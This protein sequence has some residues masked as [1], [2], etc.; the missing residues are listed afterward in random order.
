MYRPLQRKNI[1]VGQYNVEIPTLVAPIE[2]VE[3]ANTPPPIR[4][5]QKD[6]PPTKKSKPKYLPGE[7][8][9]KYAVK[10]S[11]PAPEPDFDL[12]IIANSINNVLERMRL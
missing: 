8:L 10:I 11:P 6:L 1:F 9:L 3:V 4:Y 12:D 7:R 2:V 5:I